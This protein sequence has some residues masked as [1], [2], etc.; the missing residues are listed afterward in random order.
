MKKPPARAWLRAVLLV[1]TVFALAIAAAVLAVGT[2]LSERSS[3]EMHPPSGLPPDQRSTHP[4]VLTIP[5]ELPPTTGK[6]PLDL[7]VRITTTPPA[8]QDTLEASRGYLTDL[9]RSLVKSLPP[10]WTSDDNGLATLR[11]AIEEA[12]PASLAPSLPE[13]TQ[14]TVEMSAAPPAL[15]LSP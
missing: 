2:I 12:V 9:L 1:P 14:V 7:T 10:D 3:V 13:G 15:P 11:R 6:G 5:V 4:G 8:S